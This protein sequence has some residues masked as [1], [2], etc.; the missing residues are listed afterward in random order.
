MAESTGK[1]AK[2]EKRRWSDDEIENLI[3]L[4]SRNHVFGISFAKSIANVT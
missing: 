1:E 2:V 3:D 4:Y